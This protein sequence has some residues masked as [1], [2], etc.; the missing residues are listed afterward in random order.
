MTAISVKNMS[1]WRYVTSCVTSTSFCLICPEL[2]HTQ[3]CT[4]VGD[5]FWEYIFID[6]FVR[7]VCYC[8]PSVCIAFTECNS[9]YSCIIIV[10]AQSFVLVLQ[11]V[12][13]LAS[14]PSH[15]H[16]GWSSHF[17]WHNMSVEKWQWDES[18]KIDPICSWKVGVAANTECLLFN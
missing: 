15:T 2:Q 14:T 18:L 13:T 17:F 3:L 4:S 5:I 6:I 11:N 9:K 1:M 12:I 7:S 16:S 8:E 10:S